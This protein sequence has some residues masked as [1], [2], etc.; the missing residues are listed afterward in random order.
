MFQQK[1]LDLDDYAAPNG[2]VAPPTD[3]DLAYII[4]FQQIC[5]RYNINFAEADPDERE[6]V[7]HMAEKSFGIKQA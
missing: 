1:F 5:H 4:H 6:F 3:E 7:V 2:Y